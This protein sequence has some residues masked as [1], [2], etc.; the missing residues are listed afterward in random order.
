MISPLKLI[1][2][3]TWNRAKATIANQELTISNHSQYIDKLEKLVVKL[4]QENLPSEEERRFLVLI[5]HKVETEKAL[6]FGGP[7]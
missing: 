2:Q 6:L 1:R 3:S 4:Y 5:T 7:K